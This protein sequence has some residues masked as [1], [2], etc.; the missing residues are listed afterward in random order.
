MRSIKDLL[1]ALQLAQMIPNNFITTAT[2]QVTPLVQPHVHQ[3]PTCTQ[4][5]PNPSIIKTSPPISEKT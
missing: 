2:A 3:I 4:Q 5:Q 1:K